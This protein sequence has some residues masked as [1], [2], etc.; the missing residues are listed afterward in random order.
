MAE[1]VKG[2]TLKP[3]LFCGSSAELKTDSQNTHAG[4]VPF[5]FVKCSNRACAI[6]TQMR[7]SQHDA[8]TLWDTRSK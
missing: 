3:C 2:M 4:Y 8:V 1:I 5:Y 6:S 7:G